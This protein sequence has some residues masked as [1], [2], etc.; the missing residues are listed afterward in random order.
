GHDSPAHPHSHAESPEESPGPDAPCDQHECLGTSLYANIA[1]ESVSLEFGKSMVS[2]VG[3]AGFG[4][5]S[6]TQTWSF[7]ATELP[8]RFHDSSG[9]SRARFQVWLI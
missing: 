8:F 1:P 2:F 5:V 6:P 7:V 4:V 9:Q 3:H